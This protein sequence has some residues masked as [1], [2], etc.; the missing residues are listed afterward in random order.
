MRHLRILLICWSDAF[1]QRARSIVWFLIAFILP[2]VTLLFWQGAFQNRSLIGGWTLLEMR[3]YY[4]LGMVAMSMLMAHVE[5]HV[6]YRDIKEGEIAARLLKPI[7]Y[8]WMMIALE[9]P[10]RIIQGVIGIFVLLTFL[11]FGVRIQF[12]VGVETIIM[13]ILISISAFLLSYFLKMCIGILAFWFTDI[14]ALIET[15]EVLMLVFSGYIMPVDLLPWNLYQVSLF[16]PFPYIIYFPIMASR[17][18]FQWTP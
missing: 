5:I 16:T 17:A 11:A 10:W 7:S 12:A 18:K 6:A 1:A 2:L 14:N 8:L 15:Q 13:G 4:L 9:T 3:S